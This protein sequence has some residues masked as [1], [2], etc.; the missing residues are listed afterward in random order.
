V[1][2]WTD[3]IVRGYLDE[4]LDMVYIPKEID[5]VNDIGFGI[6]VCLSVTTWEPFKRDYAEIVDVS[7]YDLIQR[8]TDA[9]DTLNRKQRLGCVH[10]RFMTVGQ[11]K[12]G[13]YTCWPPMVVLSENGD[14][15]IPLCL[16]CTDAGRRYAMTQWNDDRTVT[17]YDM[18][19]A[20]LISGQYNGNQYL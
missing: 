6:G 10:V 8:V 7:D 2:T 16:S 17:E 9:V 11:R 4:D 12:M 18:R 14:G 3:T 19:L 15:A 1:D 5:D 20:E 13:L